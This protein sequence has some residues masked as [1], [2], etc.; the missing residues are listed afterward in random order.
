MSF[1][2]KHFSFYMKVYVYVTK[3]EKKKGEY[4]VNFY[5][6]EKKNGR[7]IFRFRY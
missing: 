3:R 5:R 7:K 2:T 6:F 1:F 4:L